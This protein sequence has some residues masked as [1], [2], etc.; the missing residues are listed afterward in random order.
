MRVSGAAQRRLPGWVRR[1]SSGALIALVA[2][3]AGPTAVRADVSARTRCAIEG[4]AGD[5]VLR[6]TP[7]ADVIC[8]RGGN[9]TILGRR[10]DDTI[11]GGRGRD[12]IEGGAGDDRIMGGRGRDELRGGDGSGLGPGR[13]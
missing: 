8:G 2:V 6:G 13:A 3:S 12:D 5:D 1:L 9:D 10:G 4:T 7:G 11:H